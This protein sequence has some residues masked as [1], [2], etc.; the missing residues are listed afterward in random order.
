M[1][2][3]RC[4]IRER[5]IPAGEM[6]IRDSGVTNMSMSASAMLAAKADLAAHSYGECKELADKLVAASS[7]TEAEQLFAEWRG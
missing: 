5:G 4:L 3:R 6:C 2:R 1:R 7:A